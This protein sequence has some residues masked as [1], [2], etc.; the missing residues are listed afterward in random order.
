[1]AAIWNISSWKISLSKNLSEGGTSQGRV[2]ESL[3]KKNA[4]LI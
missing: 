2:L 3:K 1:M 4:G